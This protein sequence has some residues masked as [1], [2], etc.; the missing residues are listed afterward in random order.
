MRSKLLG[1]LIC[2]EYGQNKRKFDLFSTI[3]LKI[4]LY[5]L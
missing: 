5:I 4:G 1:E 2:L 3:I